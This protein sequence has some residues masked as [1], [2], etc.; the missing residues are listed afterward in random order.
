VEAPRLP[1]GRR[2]GVEPQPLHPIPWCAGW[3][4]CLADSRS[5]EIWRGYVTEF[6]KPC[7][8]REEASY[9]SVPSPSMASLS[10]TPISR[11]KRAA[12][13]RWTATAAASHALTWPGSIWECSGMAC[14]VTGD[15]PPRCLRYASAAIC[16]GLGMFIQSS[17]GTIPGKLSP[18]KGRHARTGS[19]PAPG[20]GGAW[21]AP[22]RR[23][24]QGLRKV[25]RRTWLL[26]TALSPMRAGSKRERSAALRAAFSR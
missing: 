4:L 25:K 26:G 10:L 11:R 7:T 1:S 3:L 9:Q 17:F 22:A 21:Q 12:L 23:L 24:V 19:S 8:D 16:P 13:A 6:S 14:P 5:L 2:R 20:D 15:T 18:S